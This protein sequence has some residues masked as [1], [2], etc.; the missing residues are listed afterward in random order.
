MRVSHGL[1][2]ACL[3]LICFLL[4]ITTLNCFM[5]TNKTKTTLQAVQ[6]IIGY[7]FK[8]RLLLWEAMQGVGSNVNSAGKRAF[9]DS[10]KRL[11]VIG[12]TVLQ[13]VIAEKWYGGGTT[14]STVNDVPSW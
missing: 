10:N 8:E 9:V 7:R 2:K 4:H 1:S 12:D 5:A 13:L 14:R 6:G 3:L 11:A